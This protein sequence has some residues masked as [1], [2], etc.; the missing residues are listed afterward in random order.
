[1]GKLSHFCNKNTNSLNNTVIFEIITYEPD[2]SYDTM[3]VLLIASL[4]DGHP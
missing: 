2:I 3:P 1:M 4:Y